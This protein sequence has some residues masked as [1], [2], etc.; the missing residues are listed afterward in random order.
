M[1]FESC[2]RFAFQ[3]LL[4]TWSPKE[5]YVRVTLPSNRDSTERRIHHIPL[6]HSLPPTLPYSQTRHNR[7][8]HVTELSSVSLEVRASSGQQWSLTTDYPLHQSPLEVGSASRCT[9]LHRLLL[10]FPN[11]T[12]EKPQS[13]IIYSTDEDASAGCQWQDTY[14]TTATSTQPSRNHK[15]TNPTVLAIAVSLS[16]VH[17]SHYEPRSPSVTNSDARLGTPSQ[18]EQ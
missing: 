3:K 1:I 6:R 15:Q 18:L 10:P 2:L 9:L 12:P 8:L 16:L 5:Q 17:R 4:G 13:S 11:K 14:D 7:Y